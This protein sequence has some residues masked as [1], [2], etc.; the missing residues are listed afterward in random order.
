MIFLL[1]F[2]GTA[3]IL[4]AHLFAKLLVF[5]TAYTNKSN[6]TYNYANIILVQNQAILDWKSIWK[7]INKIRDPVT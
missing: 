6:V 3:S 2:L 7:W 5:G 4:Q 1:A